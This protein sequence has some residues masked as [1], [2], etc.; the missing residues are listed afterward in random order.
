[1]KQTNLWVI[2]LALIMSNTAIAQVYNTALFSTT[3]PVVETEP[4]SGVPN[5]LVNDHVSKTIECWYRF[6]SLDTNPLRSH[7]LIYNA[8]TTGATMLA[9]YYNDSVIS[10]TYAGVTLTT[11]APFD[12]MWHHLA[13]IP[14]PHLYDTSTSSYYDSMT[15]YIDGNVANSSNTLSFLPM[16]P[17]QVIHKISIGASYNSGGVYANRFLG[18][19]A[20][21]AIY[22]TALYNTSFIPDCVYDTVIFPFRAIRHTVSYPCLLLL[23]LNGDTNEYDTFGVNTLTNT[24]LYSYLNSPC[25][26]TYTFYRPVTAPDTP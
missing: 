16:I 18:N 13:F 17:D 7:Y 1:M 4:L 2:L 21:I 25:S 9:I 11:N 19:I 24:L 12:T 8:S 15:L 20:K 23:P 14:Q 6:D 10:T 5:P 22:D 3:S 26:P